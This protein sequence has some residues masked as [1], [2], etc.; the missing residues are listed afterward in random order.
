MALECTQPSITNHIE[1][2]L[3]EGNN[4]NDLKIRL[5]NFVTFL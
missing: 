2:D 3:N 1:H 4:C 5:R